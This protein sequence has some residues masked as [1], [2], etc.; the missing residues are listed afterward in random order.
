MKEAYWIF[1]YFLFFIFYFLFFAFGSMIL[2]ARYIFLNKITKKIPFE[3][4]FKNN[5]LEITFTNRIQYAF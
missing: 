2:P 1:I 4:A 5:E 3:R